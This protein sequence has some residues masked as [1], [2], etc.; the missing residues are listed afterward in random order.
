MIGFSLARVGGIAGVLWLMAGCAA[1]PE[2]PATAAA[3]AAHP[4]PAPELVAPAAPPS[5]PATASVPPGVPPPQALPEAFESEAFVV[6]FAK[7]GDTAETLASRFLGDRARAWMIEDYN[8]ASAFEAGQE[9][10]IPKRPWNIAGVE[11]GGYQIVPILV[12]HNIGSE[13]RGRLVIAARTFEEQ[14]RYLKTHGYRVVSLKD[15]LEFTVLKR[16]LPRKTVVLTFDDG[17]KPF[18]EYA[19]PVLKELGFSATLFIYT[20]FVGARLGLSWEEL[21]QLAR[22]GFDIEAHTKTHNDVRRRSDESPDEFGR[23]MQA[24]LVQPL[25]VF[26]RQLGQTPT[27]LAYPYGAHDE[28]VLGHV[29]QAGYVA[30]FDVR[31]EGNPSFV[32]VLT[33]HR[34]QIYA[35]MTLEDFAKN[36]NVFS[37]EPIR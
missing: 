7:A 22:D 31:R 27:I 20:D 4:R 23:R 2:K 25:A 14:M 16:Q 33:M 37:D 24:E 35:D 5:V 6:V 34:S 11:P 29:K 17:W 18:R 21:R 19:Y 12:Y 8:R 28:A 1:A 15:F 32:P 36:L 13:A 30:A 9:V 3:P 10:V 26:Q